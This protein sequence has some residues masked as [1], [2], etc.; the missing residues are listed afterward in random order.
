MPEAAKIH[1]SPNKQVARPSD[2]EYKAAEA[3]AAKALLLS[4]AYRTPPV[5]K[6]FEVWYSYAAGVP[7]EVANRLNGIIARQGAV[8]TYDIDQVHLEFLA[9][10]ERE[11]KHQDAVSLH[12][13]HE[14]DEIAKL[15]QAHISSSGRYSNSLQQTAGSLGANAT[16]QQ[17][18]NAI[19]VLLA[20]NEKMCGQTAR[21]GDALAESRAQVR[22]LRASLEKSRERELRDP[23]TSLANRRYFE[24]RLPRE[25]A[26]ARRTGRP[27]CI[28]FIDLDHFKTINDTFG[29]LVGDD[30]LRYV[31]NILSAS[32]RDCDL[33]ARYGGEEFILIL[34]G[35]SA[36]SARSLV[37]RIMRELEETRLVLSQGKTPLGRLT[38]SFGIAQHQANDNA[39][40]LVARADA[41][42][43]EAKKAGRNRIAGDA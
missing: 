42:L 12:L 30:V 3:L 37:A 13:D 17:V 2:A 4:N 36:A 16:P 41:G 6:T 9:M 38:A 34:P 18:R 40:S 27:L 14:M 10:S 22:R 11:R 33:A 24:L 7:E 20:E 8:E 29:H 1:Q 43:Y 19:A 15:V 28:V 32:L 31:A 23:M 5:P 21:L 39:D 25:I 26:E 35:T